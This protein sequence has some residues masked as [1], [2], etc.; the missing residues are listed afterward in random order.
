METQTQLNPTTATHLFDFDG[1]GNAELGE[2]V[3]SAD[4]YRAEPAP[5]GPDA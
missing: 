4:P 5:G 3:S 2:L 1:V